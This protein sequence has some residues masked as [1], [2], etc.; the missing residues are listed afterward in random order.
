MVKETLSEL[1][2]TPDSNENESVDIDDVKSIPSEQLTVSDSSIPVDI[3]SLAIIFVLNK[4]P[5]DKSEKEKRVR[6]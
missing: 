3:I 6:D 4:E 5:N 2:P 1:L